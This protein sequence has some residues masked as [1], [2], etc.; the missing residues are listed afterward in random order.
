MKSGSIYRVLAACLVGTF[1]SACGPSTKDTEGGNEASL[2]AVEV[3]D[4][5]EVEK[6]DLN[7]DGSADVTKTYTR[8]GTKETPDENRE[9]VL[10]RTDLDVNFDGETD[11]RQFFNKIGAMVREEMDLDFDGKTDAIDYFREGIVFKRAVFLNFTETPSVWKYYEEGVLVKK[12]RD[13]NG[14][15]KPDTFEFFEEGKIVRVGYD[16][17]GDG[18]PDYWD[19]VEVVE[20]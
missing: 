1:I 6:F 13:T 3:T 10:A 9:R 11:M 17:N 4:V 19:E 16:R 8:L 20:E 12:E 18:K 15:T 7:G 14:N 5:E 2:L